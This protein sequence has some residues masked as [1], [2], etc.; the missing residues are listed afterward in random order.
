MIQTNGKARAD[1]LPMTAEQHRID[2]LI[3]DQDRR[4]RR[5]LLLLA[6]CLLTTFL[7][8]TTF[9]MGLW[10]LGLA[11]LADLTILLVAVYS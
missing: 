10:L 8:G 3:A 11:L 7:A 1:Q 6:A 9:G 4:W 2:R 5:R